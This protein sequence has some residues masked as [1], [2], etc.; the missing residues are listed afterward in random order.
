M[1]DRRVEG[2]A[3]HCA[4]PR[5]LGSIHYATD[6]RAQTLGTRRMYYWGSNST[7]AST[8][9]IVRRVFACCGEPQSMHAR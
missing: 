1:I 2:D 5:D 8:L 9:A 7:Y 4:L 3:R 6:T